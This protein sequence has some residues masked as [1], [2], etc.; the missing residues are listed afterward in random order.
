MKTI[1]NA[2]SKPKQIFLTLGAFI[3]LCILSNTVFQMNFSY[4]TQ[5]NNYTPE[6]A[7]QLISSIGENGRAAHLRIFIADIFM[8]VLYCAFLLGA[9]YN[10]FHYWIK[11]CKAISLLTFFPLILGLVQL[12]EISLL[13]VMIA[14]YQNQFE[15]IARFAN[16][17]TMIKTYMTPVCFIL[18]IIGLCGKLIMMSKLKRQGMSKIG[19]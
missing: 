2:L 19:Q 10:T 6:Q 14:N 12:V 7:Y 15:G 16:V 3:V 5:T 13:T 4:L 18:P 17:L 8:V 9:N 1:I 11:N